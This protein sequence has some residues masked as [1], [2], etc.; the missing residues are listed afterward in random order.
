ML[1]TGIYDL[2]Q[3]RDPRRL[4]SFIGRPKKLSITLY[5]QV[6]H[7]PNADELAERILFFFSDERGA[8]KRTYARRYDEFDEQALQMMQECFRADSELAVHDMAVSDGRT[9]VDFFRKVASRFAQ[10]RF[11]A[12][13]YDAEVHVLDRG[14]LKVTLSRSGSLLEFV[15]PP[16]VFNTRHPE[17]P[18]YYPLN[19]LMQFLVRKRV[20]EP[21]VADCLSRGETGRRLRIFSMEAMRL[22]GIDE[23]FV[24]DRHDMLEPAGGRYHVVRAM[25]VLNPS[26]FTDDELGQV[27]AHISDALY[28]DGILLAGSNEAVGSVVNGGIYRKRGGGFER[29]GSSGSGLPVESRLSAFSRDRIAGA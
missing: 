9:S 27:F 23:R 5:D 2:R 1:K 22:S 14:D 18:L 20:V 21:F 19:R 24:L 3:A 16:F 25:N 7:E 26:Y 15:W 13:D 17:H 8:Y 4:V 6:A 28:P 29:I 11:L 10:V 12:S